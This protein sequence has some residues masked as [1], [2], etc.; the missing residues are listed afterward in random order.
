M[1]QLLKSTKVKVVLSVM[2]FALILGFGS[3]MV[4]SDPKPGVATADNDGHDHGAEGEKDHQQLYICPMMCID[5]QPKPGRCPVCSMDLVPMP[6][7]MAGDRG[8]A[9]IKLS[10][11]MQKIAQIE[12]AAVR[13]GFAEF[14]LRLSGKVGFDETGEKVISAWA[15]GRLER[16]YVDSSGT[17]VRK[18]E[19]LVDIY[20][21]KLNSEKAIY[22]STL[23]D[24]A[25]NGVSKER[26]KELNRAR[27]RLMG[28]TDAQIDGMEKRKD[29]SYTEQILSPITGTVISKQV[30]EGMYVDEG[31]NLYTI[32]DL[33]QVWVMLDVYESDLPFI[34]YGQKAEVVAPALGNLKFAGMVTFIDPVLNDMT[35]TTRIRIQVKNTELK[36]KPNMLVRAN[37]KVRIGAEG[38]VVGAPE[39]EGKWICPRH[40]EVIS[41]TAGVCDKSG[42]KL[43]PVE[44]LGYDLSDKA[45]PA[46]LA[47]ASSILF[48]G[49]RGYAYVADPAVPGKFKGVEVE[50]GPKAGGYY[51]IKSGLKK[52]DKVAVNG[53]FRIDSAMQ[54]SGRPS[55]MSESGAEQ[56]A[57]KAKGETRIVKPASKFRSE[58]RKLLDDYF[59]LQRAL[60]S[61]DMGEAKKAQE[62]LLQAVQVFGKL[63][64]DDLDKQQKDEVTQVVA[65]IS[66]A[67]EKSVK[68]D[69]IEYVRKEFKTISS[70]IEKLVRR[71]GPFDD[72]DIYYVFCPMAFKDTG[73][74]WMQT[75]KTVHNPYEGKR[76]RKCGFIREQ[77]STAGK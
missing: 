43:K 18:G 8:V 4:S 66:G 19:P 69:D 45:E 46:V 34:R 33:S 74:Y 29:I 63:P 1:R 10:E 37:I 6:A 3:G 54:L 55:M 16:V 47:P 51:V 53:A 56:I 77:L 75:D 67:L 48:T 20:S 39:L 5:P 70:E 64:T 62:Q 61:D 32:A 38:R 11:G 68:S 57:A 58:L 35:R 49:K 44:E 27:L 14:D 13:T 12:T 60:G 40:P 59:A 65:G 9:E 2:V 28:L 72:L 36:L 26:R 30:R 42:L 17:F 7:D 73:A 76:M 71:H 23:N 50:L 25:R 41:D 22:L 52:N 24:K 31:Q 15:P 21:K